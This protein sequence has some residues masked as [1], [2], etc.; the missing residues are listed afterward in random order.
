MMYKIIIGLLCIILCAC[1]GVAYSSQVQ[2]SEKCGE[3][4]T[5]YIKCSAASKPKTVEE[6]SFWKL[7]E[8]ILNI[9]MGAVGIAAVGGIVWSGVLYASASDNESQTQQAKELIRNVVI[10]L[11]LFVSMYAILQYLIPGGIFA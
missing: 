11:V 8:I 4:K 7:I 10:G 9:L 6:S 3:V 1:I 5:S 2:A